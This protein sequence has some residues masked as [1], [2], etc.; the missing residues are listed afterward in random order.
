[1]GDG[2][3]AASEGLRRPLRRR[4]AGR[5]VLLLHLYK[6]LQS[7]G[8]APPSWGRACPRLRLHHPECS[9]PSAVR[10]GLAA[11]AWSRAGLGLA[12]SIVAAL[13]PLE[14]AR[15][16]ARQV[17]AVQRRLGSPALRF[18][19]MADPRSRRWS[20]ARQRFWACSVHDGPPAIPWFRPCRG[21][22][23]S[24]SNAS[25]ARPSRSNASR[26]RRMVAVRAAGPLGP[27]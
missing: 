20:R 10:A 12:E 13:L 27:S 9:R 24:R 18:R 16:A 5:A 22:R 23:P 26:A 3:R 19:T 6:L 2:R 15:D 4:W 17:S 21:A 11:V 7:V 25:R 14:Q 8:A 1:M